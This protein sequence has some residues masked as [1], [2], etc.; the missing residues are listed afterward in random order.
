MSSSEKRVPL[1]SGLKMHIQAGAGPSVG[2]MGAILPLSE[3]G[4]TQR[5][6]SSSHLSDL[7]RSTPAGDDFAASGL[8]CF[9]SCLGNRPVGPSPGRPLWG[10][11]EEGEGLVQLEAPKSLSRRP[12]KVEGTVGT[13][14]GG[15]GASGLVGSPGDPGLA[16][17][18]G[19]E[20]QAL[21]S[22]TWFLARPPVRR[23]QLL[24]KS[25]RPGW[26]S[27]RPL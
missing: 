11:G 17:A 16:F 19:R 12:R 5:K 23:L 18:P 8:Y 21:L 3:V 1:N 20:G 13:S 14:L 26:G 22:Q 27:E 2:I 6:L 25:A 9:L 15:D 10:D 7:G 24:P 4:T